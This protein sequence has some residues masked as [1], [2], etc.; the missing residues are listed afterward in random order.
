MNIVQVWFSI[1]SSTIPAIPSSGLIELTQGYYFPIGNEV[2]GRRM[3]RLIIDFDNLGQIISLASMYGCNPIIIGVQDENG[4]DYEPLTYP[5]NVTEFNKF[6]QP[7][8]TIIDGITVTLQAIDNTS[9][10]WQ[11]FQSI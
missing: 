10:G 9:A 5:K 4:G 6:M 8:I 7:I 3:G 1:N 11:P 2:D